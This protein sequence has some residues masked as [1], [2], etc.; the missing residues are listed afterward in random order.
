MGE[1]VRFPN[2]SARRRVT[3]YRRCIGVFSRRTHT[4]TT[5]AFLFLPFSNTPKRKITRVQSRA[6]S[7]LAGAFCSFGSFLKRGF[8]AS[9]FHFRFSLSRLKKGCKKKKN[10]FNDDDLGSF[11]RFI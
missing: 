7:F 1:F 5:R 2:S 6:S 9:R 3:L 8:H 11:L 10:E 4:W